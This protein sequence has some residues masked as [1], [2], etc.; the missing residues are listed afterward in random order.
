MGGSEALSSQRGAFSNAAHASDIIG[1]SAYG[2]NGESIGSINDLLIDSKGQVEAAI[3]DV[4]G[5][6]GMGQHSVAINWDQMKVTP[7][8]SRVIVSMTKDQLKAAPEYKK[9]AQAN[10]PNDKQQAKTP[11]N[12]SR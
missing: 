1:K 10:V 12:S 11:E 9:S 7:S 6:L 5:F 8:D 3:V 2:A 4:G